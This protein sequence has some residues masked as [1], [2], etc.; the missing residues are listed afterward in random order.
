MLEL[1]DPFGWHGLDAPQLHHVRDKLSE[2]EKRTWK[3]IL[4]ISSYY[5][6]LIEVGRLCK[7][8]RNRLQ[9]IGQEDI[10]ELLSL[11]LTG[12]E[13]VWG[14][15]EHNVVKLLWWDPNHQVCEVPLRNT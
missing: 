5:N 9:E 4:I 1:A 12:T 15:L 3:E 7:E 14:I 10:D 8:A 13:R 11:R 6:H 2:L